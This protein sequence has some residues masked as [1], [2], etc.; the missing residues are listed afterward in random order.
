MTA[1]PDTRPLLVIAGAGSGKTNTLAHRVA[2]LILDGADPHRMLLL[3]FS[4]RAAVEMEQRVAGVL[5]RVLGLGSLQTPVALPWS[6]TFHSVGA[7]LLR[8]FAGRIGL[9]ENF[10]IQDRG[11]AEDLMAMVRN[12]LGLASTKNRFPQKGTCARGQYR[13]A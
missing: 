8:D 4:R 6:G 10:T 9:E 3:T 5:R 2:R 13:A 7:R 12:D 1:V 11:D